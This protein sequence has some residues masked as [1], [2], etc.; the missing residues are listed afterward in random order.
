MFSEIIDLHICICI[1]TSH[2]L[3]RC[4]HRLRAAAA[5]DPVSGRVYLFS[6]VCYRMT[7]SHVTAAVL[8]LGARFL[9]TF[10]VSFC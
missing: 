8:K 7:R 4:T 2:C 1:R 5:A 6:P 10:Q 9:N 3:Y